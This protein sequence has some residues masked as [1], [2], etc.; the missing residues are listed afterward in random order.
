VTTQAP[1]LSWYLEQAVA[2]ALGRVR[3][4]GPA[5][6]TAYDAERQAATV[7]PASPLLWKDP[8]TDELSVVPVDPIAHVPVVWLA[9]GGAS[10]TMPLSAGDR[11]LLIVCDRS[12]DGYRRTGLVDLP[13]EDA[14]RCNLADAVFLPAR[15]TFADPLD[16]A[17]YAEGATVLRGDDVRLGSSAAAAGVSLGP[18]ADNNFAAVRAELDLIAAAINALP[19]GAYVP[20]WSPTTTTATKV[21]AE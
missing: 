2:S 15:L 20:T 4:A 21:K 3:V 9:V 12:T 8:D 18:A 16:A 6:V 1:G 13:P 10:L 7:K 11:G 5:I 17:A 14:R 19:G